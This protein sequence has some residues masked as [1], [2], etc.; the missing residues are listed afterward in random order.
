VPSDYERGLKEEIWGVF[1]YMKIPMETVMKMPIQ[2]RKFYIMRHNY[3]VEME[4]GNRYGS[5]NDVTYS[6]PDAINMF[7]RN[8][9]EYEKN[10][11]G[12]K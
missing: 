3:E 9:T 10:K 7:S 11:S 4:K 8:Q 6:T 1:K 2:D 12:S 5:T